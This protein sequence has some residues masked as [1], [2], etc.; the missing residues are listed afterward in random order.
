M[1]YHYDDVL[2]LHIFECESKQELSAIKTWCRQTLGR[3][4]G[5]QSTWWMNSRMC[6]VMRGGNHIVQTLLT[7]S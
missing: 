3:S 7:W 2:L 6:L 4:H 1:K 5:Q